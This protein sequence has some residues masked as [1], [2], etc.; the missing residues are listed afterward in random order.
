[1]TWKQLWQHSREAAAALHHCG[2]RARQRIGF[3]QSDS[4]E[5]MVY[6]HAMILLGCVPV[7]IQPNA[8]QGYVD[9]ICKTAKIDHWFRKVDYVGRDPIHSYYE[10]QDR[11]EW[12]ILT[13]SGTTANPKLIRHH[14]H[15]LMAT[16]LDSNP[17][18]F[19]S[20]HHVLCGVPVS[21][22]FGIIIAVLGGMTLGYHTV[23]LDAHTDTRRLKDFL[24]AHAITHAMIT[25][26]LIEFI[27]QHFQELPRSLTTIYSS[28]EALPLHLGDR[29]HDK[30]GTQ[31]YDTYG[32][33]E[34][35]TWS[36]I[37][38]SPDHWK[39][40]SMGVLGA[41]AVASIRDRNGDAVSVGQ[42][43]ELWIRHRN[44]AMEYLGDSKRQAEN[45]VDGWFRTGDYMSQDSDG[46]FFYAGRREHLLEH[47][48]AWISCIEI[49]NRLSRDPAIR[50]CVVVASAR[51]LHAYILGKP[52][53]TLELT[54]QFQDVNIVCDIPYTESNKKIRH[55][56]KLDQYVI[57]S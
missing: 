33:G 30:F 13:S 53:L 34:C 20:G 52:T 45:F 28:G 18:Q 24:T 3:Q 42:I 12:I 49:E 26:R 36:L 47:D 6:F 55:M 44:L 50:D 37:Q 40:G 1:M 54:T 25:P 11:D 56:S 57:K 38:T 35:R 14:Q 43:G 48:G 15:E 8:D 22:S 32:F 39:R 29:F 51:G 46:F 2:Y 4:V 21:T 5:W 41:N 27:C 31:I 10:Y 23:M 16:F 17:H 19:E 9:H 7:V